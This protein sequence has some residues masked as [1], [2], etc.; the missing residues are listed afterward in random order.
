MD[1]MIILIF[2]TFLGQILANRCVFPFIMLVDFKI[3]LFRVLS[4][5]FISDTGLW[6]YCVC[7]RFFCQGH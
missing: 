4:C 7:E 2:Y 3:I 6:F 5:I 1:M